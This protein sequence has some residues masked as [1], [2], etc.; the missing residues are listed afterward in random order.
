MSFM[1]WQLSRGVLASL[2]ATTPGSP[3][4]RGV[5]ERLLRDGCEAVAQWRARRIAVISHD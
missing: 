5:N 2:T 3:W 1:R 4:W